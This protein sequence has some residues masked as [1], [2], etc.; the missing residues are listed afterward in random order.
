MQLVLGK[1]SA[2]TTSSGLH[3]YPSLNSFKKSQT[4]TWDM[5]AQYLHRRQDALEITAQQMP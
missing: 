4:I 1:N 5:Y 2:C 3:C